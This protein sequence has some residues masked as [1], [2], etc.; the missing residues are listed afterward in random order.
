L[1]QKPSQSEV[2]AWFDIARQSAEEADGGYWFLYFALK[3]YKVSVGTMRNL[4]ETV[5][6][7]E[8]WKNET[9]THFVQENGNMG[10]RFKAALL[11][12]C[13]LSPDVWEA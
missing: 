11:S 8:Y 6:G 12:S 10:R 7:F 1:K 5:F 9:L 4:V 13:N 3:L 2:Q